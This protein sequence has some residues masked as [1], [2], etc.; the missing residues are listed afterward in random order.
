MNHIYSNKIAR[1]WWWKTIAIL[2][3]I[4]TFYY[5]FVGK[6]PAMDVLHETIRNLYFHVTMWMVMMLMMFINAFYSIRYLGSLKQYDD[7]VAEEAGKTALVF[8]AAGLITG[9][10]WANYT[11]GAPWTNDPQLNGTA[12]TILIYAAYFILRNAIPDERK[13]AKIA[14]V[15]AIFAFVMMFVFIMV[16][17]KMYNSLHPGKGG[18]PGFNKYDLDSDMR[19]VFYPAVI[20]WCLLGTWLLSLKVRIRKINESI[21]EN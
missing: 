13:K 2:C 20:G 3:L 16:I 18:N 12:A 7:L 14:G 11:W 8:A 17:P 5:G 19:K 21:E 10:V 1:A 6:V 9:M 4:Y 15:Y